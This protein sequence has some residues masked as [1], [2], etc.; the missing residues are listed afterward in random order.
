[1][2]VKNFVQ[3]IPTTFFDAVNLNAQLQAINTNGLDEACCIVR[4]I[5]SSDTDVEISYDGVNLHDYV[6]SDS[7]LQL[8]FQSNSQPKNDICLLRKGTIIYVRGTAG[9]GTGFITVAGYYQAGV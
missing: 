8:P 7:D 3:A 9:A 4:I 1:M 5:N 6:R 2:A